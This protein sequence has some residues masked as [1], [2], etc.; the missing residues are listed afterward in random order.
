MRMSKRLAAILVLVSAGAI[1]G[2]NMPWTF[3]GERAEGYSIDLIS[4]EPAAGTPLVRGSSVE[5]K[6]NA[7]YV[8]SIKPEGQVFLVVQDE[9]NKR[10]E[11][12]KAPAS[13]AVTAG[14]GMLTLTAT[15][16]EVPKAKEIRIFV[17][18]APKGLE[19]TYG[20]IVIRYPIVKKR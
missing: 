10:V 4:V 13:V 18:L 1:A 6:I 8:M 12:T 15:I 11:A 9:K 3:N 20:E 17:P 7:K 14:D 5:I 16:A 2:D 19:T